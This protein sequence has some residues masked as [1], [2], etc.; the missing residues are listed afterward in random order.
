P[1][2]VLGLSVPEIVGYLCA[3]GRDLSRL[4]AEI[5]DRLGVEAWYLHATADGKLYFR[6]VENLV[7]KL[8][9]R[10]KMLEA[11]QARRELRDRLR[12]I[13]DPRQGWCYQRVEPLLALDQVT[14][15]QDKTTL[16]IIAPSGGP[17]LSDEVKRFH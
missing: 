9:S 6:N 15:D 3:P 12:E 16:L 11:E 5:I 2:A 13:F 8:E 17:G 10:V 1:N 4:K 14:L 7:S